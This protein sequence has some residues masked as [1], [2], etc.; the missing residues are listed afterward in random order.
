MN[1]DHSCEWVRA[2]TVRA[3]RLVLAPIDVVALRW[4]IQCTLVF[5]HRPDV[6]ALREGLAGLLD[7]YPFL[8]GRIVDGKAIAYDGRG[9]PFSIRTEKGC[10]VEAVQERA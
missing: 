5:D 8:G 3:G 10:G 4:L 6:E 2:R 9:I 1:R 7:H